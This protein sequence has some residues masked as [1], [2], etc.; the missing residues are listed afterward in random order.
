MTEYQSMLNSYKLLK[1]SS[2]SSHHRMQV[3]AEVTL[4]V[5]DTCKS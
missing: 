4:H 1:Y 3:M 5:H 2:I